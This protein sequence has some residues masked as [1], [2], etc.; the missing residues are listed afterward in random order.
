MAKSLAIGLPPEY[1]RLGLD[2]IV[3]TAVLGRGLSLQIVS[4]ALDP[5]GAKSAGIAEECRAGVL[6][7][8]IEDCLRAPMGH[9]AVGVSDRARRTPV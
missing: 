4:Q 2:T 7:H 9:L 3:P 1:R 8:S 5:D 6:T